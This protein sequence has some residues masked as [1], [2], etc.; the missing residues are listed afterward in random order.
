MPS[1][2]FD[3]NKF[4]YK[5]KCDYYIENEF[6]KSFNEYFVNFIET[7]SEDYNNFI[8]YQFNNDKKLLYEKLYDIVINALKIK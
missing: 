8:Y 3:V 1:F 5:F 7:N 2:S 4:I 6:D